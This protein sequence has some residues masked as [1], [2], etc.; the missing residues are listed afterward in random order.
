MRVSIGLLLNASRLTPHLMDTKPPRLTLS[1]L[2]TLVECSGPG[3]PL[4]SSSSDFI[5][6][7]VKNLRCMIQYDAFFFMEIDTYC[8]PYLIL[9]HILRYI[10]N[11]RYDMWYYN[12][13]I[14]S[15]TIFY[16]LKK[17]QIKFIFVKRIYYI[18][19]LKYTKRLKIYHKKEK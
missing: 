6:I 4:T 11:T 8:N 9:K 10:Y 12:T 7:V 5:V 13:T 3:G 18:N 19:Y 16:N 15:L 1:P 17:N 2:K 14:H